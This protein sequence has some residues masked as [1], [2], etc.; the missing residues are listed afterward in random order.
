MVQ[1]RLGAQQAEGLAGLQSRIE[2]GMPVQQA[3]T[4]FV[5]S[6]EGLKFFGSSQDPIGA[7]KGYLQLSQ[8]PADK[9]GT[10]SPGAAVL[11]EST[12]EVGATQPTTELQNTSGFMGL[13]NLSPAETQTF[14]RAMLGKMTADPNNQTQKEAAMK[15][16]VDAG[17]VDPLTAQKMLAGII[18]VIPTLDAN[19]NRTGMVAVDLTDMMQD[20]DPSK[21]KSVVIGGQNG[22]AGGYQPAGA[23][24]DPATGKKNPV[25]GDI[26]F[27]AGV[28]GNAAETAGGILGNITPKLSGQEYVGY[29]TALTAI[30]ANVNSLMNV[31]S[32][33]AAEVKI[34]ND[35]VDKD[36]WTSNPVDQG[37]ALLNLHDMADRNIAYDNMILSSTNPRLATNDNRTKASTELAALGQLKENLPS[38]DDLIRAIA[39]AQGGRGTIQQGIEQ[40]AGH[41]GEVVKGV[42]DT[43]KTAVGAGE[44]AAG[45]A[46][47]AVGEQTPPEG[48]S[49]PKVFKNEQE[50][51]AAAAA[52]KIKAGD[53]ITV[54]GV[55]GT[56]SD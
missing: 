37:V 28:V 11:N 33:L 15:Q 55:P 24:V 54:G 12:G 10:I 19:G 16:L 23:S 41:V 51:A 13:A 31:N 6:P 39:E 3:V 42:T 4:D 32:R 2:Q 35:M 43:A 26:I 48:A 36:G 47:K 27:G 18:Q 8:K 46:E 9:F 29:R 30:K 40:G 56:W 53:K 22:G 44:N 38:R 34:Y 20:G 21:A 17:K 52:G 14:G 50:A 45:A 49:G 25:S 5:G 1:S 7:I